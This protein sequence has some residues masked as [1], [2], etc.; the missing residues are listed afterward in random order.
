MITWLEAENP[1][2]LN[3]EAQRTPRGK[4]QILQSPSFLARRSLRRGGSLS[5]PGYLQAVGSPAPLRVVWMM[6]TM[7]AFSLPE[8]AAASHSWAAY[9]M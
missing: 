3:L 5:C 1:E 7:L 9:V 4:L 8:A 6:P 2:D